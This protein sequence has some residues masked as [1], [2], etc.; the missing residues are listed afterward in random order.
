M[1]GENARGGKGK[2]KV[3]YLFGAS[4]Y[5]VIAVLRVVQRCIVSRR[6]HNLFEFLKYGLAGLR[7]RAGTFT[8]GLGEDAGRLQFIK[9]STNCHRTQVRIRVKTCTF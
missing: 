5:N 1:R 9:V 7:Q 4:G 6:L 2:K 8:Y 3:E